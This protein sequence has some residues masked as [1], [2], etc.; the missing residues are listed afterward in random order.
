MNRDQR[1]QFLKEQNVKGFEG[2]IF[3]EAEVRDLIKKFN[4]DLILETGSYKGWTSKKFSEMCETHSCELMSANYSEAKANA[5]GVNFYQIQSPEFL[6]TLLASNK[7]R[8]IFCYLDA[9]GPHDT[10][11]IEELEVIKTSGVKPVIAIHD[12]KVPDHPELGYDVYHKQ[13]YTYEWI[14]PHLIDGYEYHYN[15]KAEGVMRGVIYL[16]PKIDSVN[17]PKKRGR[18]K[19][20]TSNPEA[21]N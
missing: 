17:P 4:V 8:K 14:K 10:P 16:Y 15:S 19:N 3:I 5:P 6:K 21:G 12:F 9:H 13:E 20:D 11:L 2:D 1:V 18:K 7:D